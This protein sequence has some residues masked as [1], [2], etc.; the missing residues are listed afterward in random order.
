VLMYYQ[1]NWN[2]TE[3]PPAGPDVPRVDLADY[4]A[5]LAR[6]RAEA[7]ARGI[8]IVFLTRPHRLPV[9]EQARLSGWRGT[10]TVY[11]AAL[12]DWAR[13][14]RAPVIDVQRLL[15]RHPDP[16]FMDECHLTPEGY[17]QLGEMVRDELLYSPERP[18]WLAAQRAVRER[19]LDLTLRVERQSERE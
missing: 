9:A 3:V 11:N 14:G 15:E 18:L 17:Q 6:F 10:V 4:R 5:N 8:P 12:V 2:H 13:A 7:S 19:A 1:R 16:R